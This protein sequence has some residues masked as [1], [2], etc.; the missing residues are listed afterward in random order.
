ME[1]P[2]NLKNDDEFEQS[3]NIHNK[4]F[5]N[6]EVRKRFMEIS[7]KLSPE[8]KADFSKIMIYCYS[9][10]ASQE[11]TEEEPGENGKE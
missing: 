11:A 2:F 9:A 6:E 8:D 7:D 3:L 4:L 10:G 5:A 1:A